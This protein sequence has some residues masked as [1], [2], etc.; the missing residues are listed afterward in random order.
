M[1]KKALLTGVALLLFAG[2][3][4]AHT[5]FIKLD[6]Y[7]LKPHST[8]TIALVNGTFDKSEN[9][10]ARRRMTDVSV[11]G[12]G[13]EVMHPDTSRWREQG[14]LTLLDLETGAPGTYVVGVSTAP[15]MIA[16][17]AGDFNEYL[18]HDGVLDVLAARKQNG[19][20]GLDARERYSKHVKAVLQVG[21]RRTGGFG[22][23]L[24]Y[25]A[26]I[27]PV[28]NPYA[29]GVGD[30]FEVLVLVDGHPV[31]N[32]Y[33]EA[34]HEGYHGHDAA[35]GHRIAVQTRTDETG[36]ARIP[37]EAA[38]RWYVK[39]IHMARVDDGEADYESKWA[40]LTFEVR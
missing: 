23:R 16:L 25:P 17:S 39:L 32:Q 40:T 29:L 14:T 12:P 19:E 26:E 3:L 10:I 9:A 33:V 27:V 20:L 8:A 4:N 5:L 38:G 28:N 36:V 11:V 2:I 1:K 15:S 34:S 30:T 37:L 13:D 21:D 6:T 24:G 31:V 18:E 35:G 7:F 22:H